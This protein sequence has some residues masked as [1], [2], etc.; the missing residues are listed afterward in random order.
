MS[1]GFFRKSHKPVTHETLSKIDDPYLGERALDI[2]DVTKRVIRNLQGKAPK[3]F[4]GLS[5]P[6]HSIAHNLT[7][8]DTAS[9]KRE[10]VLGLRR[11][12]AAARRIRL[13]WPVRSI[14]RR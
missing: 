13:S 8:S 1:S 6:H 10:H 5:E 3:K 4:L 7:P 12:L 14:S 11:I 9:M 2:Q